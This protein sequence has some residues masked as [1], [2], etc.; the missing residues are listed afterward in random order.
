MD[1]ADIDPRIAAQLILGSLN[2]V[3][4]WYRSDGLY[5]PEEIAT[6]FTDMSLASLS[7]PVP[8]TMPSSVTPQSPSTEPSEAGRL[9][10]RPAPSQRGSLVGH[11]V[12]DW[13]RAGRRAAA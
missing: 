6:A 2:S 9:M 3:S 8:G 1:H 12:A 13:A 10:S 5:F 4:T 11:A 7:G